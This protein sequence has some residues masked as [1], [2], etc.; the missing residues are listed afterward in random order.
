MNLE[1]KVS[2]IINNVEDNIYFIHRTTIDLPYIDITNGK[3]YT[4]EELEKSGL[5]YDYIDNNIQCL[6]NFEDF[7]EDH[8]LD[9]TANHQWVI[10]E[11]QYQEAIV[12]NFQ[13]Q[14]K[15]FFG[16]GIYSVQTSIERTATSLEEGRNGKTLNRDEQLL[17]LKETIT[18]TGFGMN[19]SKGNALLGALSNREELNTLLVLEIPRKCFAEI[20]EIRPLFQKSDTPLEVETA[21]RGIQTINTVIPTE[22]IK[23]AFHTQGREIIFE[24]NENYRSGY[25]Q[26]KG[27]YND[28]TIKE[29]LEELK[30]KDEIKD[31]DIEKIL[32]ITREGFLLDGKTSKARARVRVVREELLGKISD[33][34]KVKHFE[35]IM[36]Q[37][38]DETRN[39]LEKVSF[40]IEQ[41]DFTDMTPGDIMNVINN[42]LKNGS[43]ILTDAMDQRNWNTFYDMFHLYENVLQKIDT[44][45]LKQ[46]YSSPVANDAIALIKGKIKDIQEFNK[47]LSEIGPLDEANI[48]GELEERDIA[49]YE[50][51]C[52]EL[53]QKRKKVCENPLLEKE[54]QAKKIKESIKSISI[55]TSLQEVKAGQSELK[56]GYNELESPTQKKDNDGQ[57]LDD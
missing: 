37:I 9:I 22:Y 1:S 5:D 2:E 19:T 38:I 6:S 42:L 54:K 7:W 43:S 3:I 28:E 51:L 40:Q 49:R 31:T 24:D 13:E 45:A 35:E 36:E 50:E 56:D 27:I 15:K 55:Q 39:P 11:E 8:K 34:E 21:Y 12:R 25:L 52:V 26:S 46:L 23:G 29:I 16:Q 41:S 48:L 14:I 4:Q 30:Q 10:T 57:S 33:E 18:K 32:R 47:V 20:D 44:V 53:E 17:R